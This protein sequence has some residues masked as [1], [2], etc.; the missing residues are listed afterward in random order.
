MGG[1]HVSVSNSECDLAGV[2]ATGLHVDSKE[3][4]KA[5]GIGC[6]SEAL[7]G[8]ESSG[9]AANMSGEFT[10]GKGLTEVKPI[11]FAE[12]TVLGA[13]DCKLAD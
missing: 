6:T 2:A 10:D 11:L 7:A 13:T 12:A 8:L 1:C 9:C 4:T 3:G 5:I